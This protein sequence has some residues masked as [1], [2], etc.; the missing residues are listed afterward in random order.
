M[1]RYDFIK[2]NMSIEWFQELIAAIDDNTSFNQKCID[3]S[4]NTGND[5]VEFFKDYIHRNNEIK[6]KLINHCKEY[7][8]KNGIVSVFKNELIQLV[9]ILL[10]N[11]VISRAPSEEL[12][13]LQ[14]R[15]IEET[16]KVIEYQNKLIKTKVE[17]REFT[18][19]AIEFE[20]YLISVIEQYKEKYGELPVEEE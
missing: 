2:L 16:D 9:W 10:E 15:L 18:E 12:I 5:E 6:E 11:T 3:N 4:E 20:Q 7:C 19:K 8:E 13:E 1:A 17:F 14:E